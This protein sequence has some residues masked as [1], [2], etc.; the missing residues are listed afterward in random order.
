[1]A[2]EVPI[3]FEAD[4][5]PGGGQEPAPEPKE[6]APEPKEDE[7]KEPVP[8]SRFAEV[9]KQRN[10]AREALEAAEKAK[11]AAAQKEAEEAGKFKELW[12]QSQRDLAD[13]QLKT[14]RLEVAAAA[15]LPP[16]MASRLTGSNREELEADAKA[17]APLL[18][19]ASQGVPP[20]GR[21][22]AQSTVNLADLTPEQIRDPKIKKQIL[23]QT[24]NPDL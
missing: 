1:M 20:K 4:D 12:E 2:F 7:S 9:I 19:P 6:P 8:Y 21:S 5:P 22:K 11:K 16:E 10:E 17:L 3:Y 23:A 18:K 13:A 15:G 14:T 24:V